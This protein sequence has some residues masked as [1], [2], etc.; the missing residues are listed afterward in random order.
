MG[1]WTRS[2]RAAG[3]IAVVLSLSA[4]PAGGDA[5][6]SAATTASDDEGV[7]VST[8]ATLTGAWLDVTDEA[9][10]PTADWTNKVELAD[11]DLDGDVDLLFANG[12]DYDHA[13][14]RR[15][16]AGCS[17]TWRRHLRRRHRRTSWA[18]HR[19]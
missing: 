12:G 3:A 4:C 14:R 13:G 1:S 19:P 2:V 18:R 8:S 17:S 10:G 9:I 5:A 7:A 6:P 11:L 15:S 16:R